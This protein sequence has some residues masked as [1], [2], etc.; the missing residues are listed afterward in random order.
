[1]GDFADTNIYGRLARPREPSTNERGEYHTN[2]DG[3][4]PFGPET[5]GKFTD[6]VQFHDAGYARNIAQCQVARAES[7]EGVQCKCTHSIS[8]HILVSNVLA[9]YIET[10]SH[11]EYWVRLYVTFDPVTHTS[12]SLLL[13]LLPQEH[14]FIESRLKDKALHPFTPHPL[15]VPVLVM[16]LL[17]QEASCNLVQAHKNSVK[18]YIVADLHN[19]KVYECL[20]QD[21]LDIER[22]SEDSIRYEQSILILFEKIENAM[23]IGAKLMTWFGNFHTSSMA[24]SERQ[25]FQSADAILRNRVENLVDR[26]EMQ[27]MRLRRAHGHTQLNRLG[28]SLHC[29]SCTQIRIPNEKSLRLTMT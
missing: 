20:K 11:W 22:A 12:T 16:E 24:E 28:V 6:A 13:N 19:N 15:F 29:S 8:I 10:F 5:F 21:D 26:F 27:L 3:V 17:F 9:I 14:N 18:M 23:K 7:Q 1:M 4:L 25:S 2:T